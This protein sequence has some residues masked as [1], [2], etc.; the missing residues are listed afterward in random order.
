MFKIGEFSHI[1]RVSTR[2]LRYY[3]SLGLLEPSHT[4]PATGY[5]YYT[6]EQLP[7]LN[8]ILALKE[9][10]LSLDEVGKLLTDDVPAEQLRGMLALKRSQLAREVEEK[11]ASIRSIESRID[12]I[13]SGEDDVDLLVKHV[14]TASFASLR[15]RF[16][17][18]PAV[19]AL[20][21]HIE[22]A[23]AS[24]AGR[25]PH[26]SLAAVW[27]EDW[28]D[29]DLDL[30][31]GLLGSAISR[32]LPLATG[33]VLIPS[34]LPAAEVLSTIRVGAPDLAHGVYGAVGRWMA[35]NGARMA[36]PVRELVHQRP[37]PGVAPVVEV[38]FPIS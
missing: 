21:D 19:I 26:P 3:D 30:E 36:G 10:G 33:Q 35:A 25:L 23:A 28:S 6:A 8:R 13:E 34:T 16:A 27:H 14:D 31:I 4:D 17:D 9:M 12:Q 37:G 2:L 7:D 15:D 32:D 11:E 1:A 20:A 24:F 22:D 18:L 38:Q 5:R 29:S